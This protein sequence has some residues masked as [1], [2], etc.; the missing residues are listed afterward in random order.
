MFQGD[1]N[2]KKETKLWLI[3]HFLFGPVVQNYSDASEGW[4]LKY[5]CLVGTETKQQQ[6]TGFKD[7]ST[8]LRTKSPVPLELQNLFGKQANLTS[9]ESR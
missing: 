5:L 8:V 6:G 7:N 3:F 1:S 9:E 4:P 2:T